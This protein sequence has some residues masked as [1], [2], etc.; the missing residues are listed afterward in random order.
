MDSEGTQFTPTIVTK[1]LS[2]PPKY[3][4]LP[5]IILVA[6]L[7]LFTFLCLSCLSCLSLTPESDING[8]TIKKKKKTYYLA[9]QSECTQL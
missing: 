8:K 2:S 6:S 9:R 7:S 3:F 4:A 1:D 5:L